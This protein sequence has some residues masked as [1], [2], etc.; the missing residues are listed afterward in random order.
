MVASKI[1]TTQEEID[2]FATI[3]KLLGSDR[4]VSFE[5]SINYF[6]IHLADK[7]TWVFTRLQVDR[8]H[9]TVWVPLTP[10]QAAPHSGSRPVATNGGWSIFTLDSV[11]EIAQLGGLFGAAYAHVKRSRETGNPAEE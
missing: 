7:R 6:K 2:C 3:K 9:P 8:K 11:A 1:E 5:D 4:P 10:E